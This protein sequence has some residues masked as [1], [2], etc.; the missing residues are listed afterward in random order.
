[1]HDA[2]TMV[3]CRCVQLN[4]ACFSQLTVSI[5]GAGQPPAT[6]SDAVRMR[7][8]DRTAGRLFQTH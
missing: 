2:M 1:M 8:H 4:P 6:R 7:G 5:Q 3:V